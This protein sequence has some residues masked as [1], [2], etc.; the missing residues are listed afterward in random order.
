MRAVIQRVRA[1]S[2]VADGKPNGEIKRGLLVF[3]GVFQEDTEEDLQWLAGKVP[4][5]RV[6]EDEEGKMNRRLSDFG[7]DVM[8]ISQFTLY[9][10][11]KK[12]TRPSFNRAAGPDLA[13]PYYEKFIALLKEHPGVGR[14]AQGV[15]AA[16]MQIE[17]HND[18]P[19]TLIVDTR[20][21][22]W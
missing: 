20:D 13:V 16:D 10:N 6:F 7:G 2:V 11:L 17:A 8:V 19:V 3:L 5:I 9:G 4:Q 18:G 1:A 15:F 14:V 21:K 12:G 22:G